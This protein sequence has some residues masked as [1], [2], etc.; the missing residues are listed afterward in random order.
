MSE[1][2]CL[3]IDTGVTASQKP[4]GSKSFLEASLECASLIVERRLFSESK[5]E[6]AV[7]LFGSQAEMEKIG[8][9]YSMI[10]HISVFTRIKNSYGTDV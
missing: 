10:H 9:N 6:L 8:M 2:I 3:V 7:I 1:A 4:E 5:D